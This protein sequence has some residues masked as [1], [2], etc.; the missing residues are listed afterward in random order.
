MNIVPP[1]L[2]GHSDS[3]QVSESTARP[4]V[5]ISLRALFVAITAFCV[6]LAVHCERWREQRWAVQGILQARGN[7]RY[8]WQQAGKVY[9]P[10]PHWLRKVVGDDFFAVVVGVDFQFEPHRAGDAEMK[11]VARLYEL[12]TLDL[13]K[14]QV[15]DKGIGLLAGLENLRW[16]S[17]RK[18]RVNYAGLA[19]LRHLA[20]LQY[21]DL[22]GVARLGTLE[23]LSACAKLEHLDLTSTGLTDKRLD[24]LET[25]AAL[26]W[27]SLGNNP[28]ISDSSLRRVAGLTRLEELHL[29]NTGI[30]DTGLEWLLNLKRLKTLDLFGT[31]VTREGVAKLLRSLPKLNVLPASLRAPHGVGGK[32]SR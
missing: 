24:G 7:A 18:T 21:L 15:T 11:Y 8:D 1:K 32:Q 10:G 29:T 13:E 30:T 14:S 23:P 26:R 12:R 25:L 9:P 3:P 31:R 17:L 22:R 2:P 27:L 28:K 6:W 5:Q 20:N 4:K 16:L 19:E